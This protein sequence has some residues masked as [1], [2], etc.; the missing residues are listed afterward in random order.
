MEYQQLGIFD[1]RLHAACTFWL[2]YFY[3]PLEICI[4]IQHAAL[5]FQMC[6][7]KETEEC[8][9]LICVH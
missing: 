2:H 5:E 8:G 4:S 1:W 6:A 3:H 7:E 9:I